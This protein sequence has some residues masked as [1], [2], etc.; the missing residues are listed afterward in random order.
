VMEC[1]LYNCIIYFNRGGNWSDN[2]GRNSFTN[3]CTT[4]A[5]DGWAVG[6]ITNDPSFMNTNAGNY[7]LSQG[8]PC[9]N[10]GLNQTWMATNNVDLDGRSRIDHYSRQ[11]DMGCFEYLSSGA[12]YLVG[13]GQ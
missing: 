2:V 12:M 3:C 4:P 7:R 9:V 11:V 5:Q 6:N 8:S 10:A 1:T 13:F